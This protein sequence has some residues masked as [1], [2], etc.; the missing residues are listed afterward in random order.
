MRTSAGRYVH[1]NGED[2]EWHPEYGVGVALQ[3]HWQGVRLDHFVVKSRDEFNNIKLPRG[4]VGLSKDHP[5]FFR[6]S[7]FFPRHDRNEV[8]DPMP[9]WLIWMTRLEIMRMRSRLFRKRHG[10]FTK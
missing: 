5:E 2:V 9:S 4:D 7:R 1:T 6:D 8:H 10:L 3:C